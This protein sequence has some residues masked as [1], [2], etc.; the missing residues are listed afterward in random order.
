[1]VTD[2]NG[3]LNSCV[4]GNVA[5]L[6]KT[7]LLAPLSSLL[8]TFIWRYTLFYIMQFIAFGSN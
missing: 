1:M 4:T 6:S 3:F 7:I 8:I 2:Y 5:P